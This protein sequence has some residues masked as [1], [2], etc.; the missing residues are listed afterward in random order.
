VKLQLS[1]FLALA[2][3]LAVHPAR[4]VDINVGFNQDCALGEAMP[5]VRDAL[6]FSE[7]NPGTT[8]HL[9]GNAVY[10]DFG[11]V[12]NAVDLTIRSD[13]DTSCRPARSSA[14]VEIGFDDIAGEPLDIREGN[15]RLANIS[16]SGARGS[17]ALFIRG[18]SVILD[19]VEFAANRRDIPN[20]T[21]KARSGGGALNISSRNNLPAVVTLQD[22]V[23]SENTTDGSGGA[24]FC[25]GGTAT[26]TT[27]KIQLARQV[28]FTA[29]EAALHGGAVHLFQQCE[30]ESAPGAEVVFR[31]N[32]AADG[33]G[34][35]I[36]F[37]DDLLEATRLA[38]QR[39]IKLLDSIFEGNQALTG[40]A[41]S[42][43]GNG[44]IEIHRTLFDAN[45]ALTGGG[46]ISA[47]STA[48][49]IDSTA[50]RRN[51]AE[52]G[53]AVE[54]IRDPGRSPVGI[55]ATFSAAC[56]ST[57]LDADQYCA[58][59]ED[60]IAGTGGALSISGYGIQV[61]ETAFQ[62]NVAEVGSTMFHVTH[63]SPDQNVLF[64][65]VLVAEECGTP[66]VLIND[67]KA[68]D[69]TM[70]HVTIAPTNCAT[71]SPVIDVEPV[72]APRLTYTGNIVPD[73]SLDDQPCNLAFEQAQLV[74]SARGR[75]RL[76]RNSPGIDPSC[77]TSA[78]AHD[79]DGLP[80]SIPADAGAFEFTP[81]SELIF[82]D[83]F[84][85]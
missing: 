12:E 41:I 46:A 62:R 54:L 42:A 60:N 43:V 70:R 11:V 25:N 73:A 72:P 64:Q 82:G 84:E 58:A 31:E 35:A 76:A 18:A 34:G 6:N 83:S 24:I 30:V 65:N 85:Q 5:T 26:A 45:T 78:L 52:R 29:N 48:V 39:S 37:S 38:N 53:G 8:I 14:L 36:A 51:N 59:F 44:A 22:V 80:R 23:F 71:E 15:A 69:L 2:V 68:T 55:S 56:D 21:D 17:G 1:V 47:I 61:R 77:D 20:P 16:F 19:H 28:S 10:A 66:L 57:G 67:G 3:T 63:S 33:R 13:L 79:L 32:R 50:F 4:A 49:E 40:G 75:F 9:A 27:S 81:L 7:T 74:T